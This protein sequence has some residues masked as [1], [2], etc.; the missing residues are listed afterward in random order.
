MKEDISYALPLVINLVRYFLFAGIP[1]LIFYILFPTF[2]KKNKIQ[3]GIA[4]RKDFIRE[5][6]YSVQ[7]TLIIAAV[8][9]TILFTPLMEYTRI[10]SDLSDYPSWWIPVSILLA[11]IAH[12]TYFY[13]LH[14]VIHHP[15]IYKK[16]HLTHH[17][18]INPSPWASYSFH[19]FESVLEAMVVPI[20][21]FL[22]PIHLYS[23]FIF[24]IIIFIINVYGHLGYEVAPKWFRRSFLFEV[25]NTSVHHNLH[26]STFTSNFGL[27]F[28]F[29]DRIMGTEHP[30]YI[31]E[32]DKIQERRI[33]KSF[34]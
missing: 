17:K 16:V 34:E 2:F 14:R 3:T 31:R 33:A 5:I 27:Y 11:I 7:T 19:F 12:D 25:L 23:F 4:K 22:I 13:W 32:Y 8:A 20:V 18:S 21:L 29:W 28:R 1:F 6:M 30:D 9:M 15:S 24:T 10:Y 26:H